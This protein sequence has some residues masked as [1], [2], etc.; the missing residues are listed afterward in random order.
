MSHFIGFKKEDHDPAGKVLQG[1][2]KGQSNCQTRGA[3]YGNKGG[4]F[5]ANHSHHADNQHRL[6]QDV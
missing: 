4:H 5:D 2:L 3:Q 1:A 6:Q